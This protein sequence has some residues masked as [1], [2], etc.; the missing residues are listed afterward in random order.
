MLSPSL[1][2]AAL[3]LAAAL[4]L[5]PLGILVLGE[6]YSMLFNPELTLDTAARLA[7]TFK[8]S[9]FALT[10]A[11]VAVFALVSRAVLAPLFAKIDGASADEAQARSAAIGLPWF[12]IAVN[13]GFWTAGT[14]AFY[15]ANGWKAPNGTPFGWTL[16]FK[17][18]EGLASALLSSLLANV[19]LIGPK[20]ALLMRE[21]REGERD[22]FAELADYLILALGLGLMA[23]RL[24]Y[25]ARYFLL[26]PADAPGPNGLAESMAGVA[27]VVAALCAG[28]LALARR[29]RSERIKLLA[30]RLE[31]LSAGGGADLSVT[32]ELFSFD[33]IGRATGSF[34]SFA[35]SLRGI[36]GEVRRSAESLTAGCAQLERKTELMTKALGGIAAALDATRERTT[37]EADSASKSAAAAGEIR[38]DAAG[39]GQAIEVQS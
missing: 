19:V 27:I 39:L 11:L 23:T 16:L 35:T 10:G 36:L 30:D 33:G 20:K 24:G 37:R 8:A 2:K 17:A 32:L 13:V 28:L 5:P 1:R 38:N 9:V 15:A 3:P 4:A 6:S 18:T 34:N 12:L 7:G 31:S 22:R 29:E 26:R 25:V 14:V 21:V